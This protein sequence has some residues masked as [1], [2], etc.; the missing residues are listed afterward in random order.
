[1]PPNQYS[2]NKY[3]ELSNWGCSLTFIPWFLP[4]CAI[5]ERQNIS[6]HLWTFARA[7][8]LPAL[9]FPIY[10]ISYLILPSVLD[11]SST[12]FQRT[13]QTFLCK[14]QLL[15]IQQH[16]SFFSCAHHTQNGQMA[17]FTWAIWEHYL[18]DL[19]SATCLRPSIVLSSQESLT[20]ILWKSEQKNANKNTVNCWSSVRNSWTDSLQL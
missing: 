10:S 4:Y 7:V 15:T 19:F 11:L 18:S 12:S 1:M 13:S 20:Y 9:L 2:L 14:L 16:C 6:F 5:H 3:G 8:P 17:S